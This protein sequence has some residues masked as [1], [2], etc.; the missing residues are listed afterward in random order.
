[1][2]KPPVEAP[3]IDRVG[4]GRDAPRR[5]PKG[6]SSPGIAKKPLLAASE[7][8]PSAE[9]PRQPS[10]VMGVSL[11]EAA[12]AMARLAPVGVGDVEGTISVSGSCLAWECSRSSHPHAFFIGGS[13]CFG[14]VIP[15]RPETPRW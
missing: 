2:R 15:G 12:D 4:R 3:G 5:L 14:R 13:S 7:R 9:S 10:L 1:M 8:G 11:P 6:G